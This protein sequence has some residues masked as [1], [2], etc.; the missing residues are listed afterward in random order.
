[1]RKLPLCLDGR[2]GHHRG[3][4]WPFLE[5]EVSVGLASLS[6]ELLTSAAKIRSR[7]RNFVIEGVACQPPSS[8][9]RLQATPPL[10][11]SLPKVHSILNQCLHNLQ[12][13]QFG[14]TFTKT[15][16]ANLCGKGLKVHTT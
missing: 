4:F 5:A 13:T 2:Q 14:G 12:L 8:L 10:Q 11:T 16:L 1:M 7:L 15:F 9:R 3:S 6:M